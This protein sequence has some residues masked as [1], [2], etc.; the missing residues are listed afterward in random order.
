MI[1]GQRH[2]FFSHEYPQHKLKIVQDGFNTFK[3][4]HT[5]SDGYAHN[6]SQRPSPR[7]SYLHLAQEKISRTIL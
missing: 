5:S 2:S 6:L 3:Q 7:T 1:S 4:N